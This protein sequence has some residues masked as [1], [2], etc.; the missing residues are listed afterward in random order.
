MAFNP[1]NVQNIERLVRSVVNEVWRNRGTV[2]KFAEGKTFEKRLEPSQTARFPSAVSLRDSSAV[3]SKPASEQNSVSK[4]PK[5]ISETVLET[6]VPQNKRLKS[7]DLLLDKQVVTLRDVEHLPKIVRRLIVPQTALLTPSVRDALDEQNI[8][9]ARYSRESI[10]SLKTNMPQENS[11]RLRAGS[12]EIYALFTQFHPETLFSSWSK[13]GWSPNLRS[14]FVC[15]DGVRESI[16]KNQTLSVL[17]T[18]KVD[19]AL[20]RLNRNEKIF[21]VSASSPH[22][23]SDQWK[24][25]PLINTIIVEPSQ[26][27][28]YLTG[29]IVQRAAELFYL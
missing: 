9:L 23:M 13:A 27:G 5:T 20:C 8:R 19:E 10:E 17:F 12:L 29:Q 1:S 6:A 16:A 18:S 15:F 22:R 26:S 4:T 7:E 2:P 25:F 24:T 14:G 11:D 3:S 28:I 21:A